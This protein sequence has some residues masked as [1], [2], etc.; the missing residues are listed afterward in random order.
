ML[1]YVRYKVEL[2]RMNKRVTLPQ[3]TPLLFFGPGL[4]SLIYILRLLLH[5][6]NGFIRLGGVANKIWTDSLY[7][8]KSFVCGGYY[9]YFTTSNK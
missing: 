5:M 6:C 2:G 4:S 1:C 3:L 7:L 9:V 8:L